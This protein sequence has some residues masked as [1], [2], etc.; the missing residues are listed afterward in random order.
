[1]R[2]I[3]RILVLTLLIVFAFLF[4]SIGSMTGMSAFLLLAFLFEAAFWIGLFRT[5]KRSKESPH[6]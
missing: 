1:M 3:Y 2:M 6:H 4:G 5:M